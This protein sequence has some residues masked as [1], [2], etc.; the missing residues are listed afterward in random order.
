MGFRFVHA[1]DLHLDSPFK[2]LAE[3]PN[4]LREQV[5]Q[6]TFTAWDKLVDLTIRCGADALLLGGDLFDGAHRTLR[7]EW[8]LRRGLD[9]LGEAHVQVFIIHG[10]HDPMKQSEPWSE[11]EHV[12]VFG[13]HEPLSLPLFN[14][15]GEWVAVVTGMSYGEAAVYDNLASLYPREPERRVHQQTG[16]SVPDSMYRIGLLHGTVDSSKDHDPYAPCTK[17]ELVQKGYDYWALGHIHVRQ[18]LSTDPYIVYPG[19][20]QSR[21]IK[22]TGAKGAYVVDVHD[23]H[24]TELAFHALDCMRWFEMELNL[25][26]ASSLQQAGDMLLRAVEDIREASEGR[27]AFV[28]MTLCASPA[29]QHDLLQGDLQQELLELW[30]ESEWPRLESEESIVWPLQIMVNREGTSDLERWREADHFIG[31][32]VRLGDALLQD[33][34]ELAALLEEVLGS[35]Y[36]QRRLR[37]W[38]QHQS[39]AE[40]EKWMRH[41]LQLVVGRLDQ[42]GEKG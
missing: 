4:E 38:L 21:H 6:S 20:L 5:L 26:E 36:G 15:Q 2:G 23:D 41:A 28:R 18:L 12:H 42:G 37:Q 40:Q 32:V 10:N 30:K 16:R 11:A 39:E 34:E 35:F 27:S 1:A 29:V 14:Q 22:E 8:R 33:K 13:T 9:R 24:S 19:N 17:E 31:D 25:H 7:A 3:L